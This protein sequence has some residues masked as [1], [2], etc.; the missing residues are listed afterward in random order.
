MVSK[1]DERIETIAIIAQHIISVKVP[2][3]ERLR[4]LKALS[5]RYQM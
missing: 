4:Y 2:E 3:Q 5:E 1:Q